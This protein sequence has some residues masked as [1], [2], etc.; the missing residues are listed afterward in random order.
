MGKQEHLGYFSSENIID[1]EQLKSIDALTAS[2]M[3]Q[4][5][6]EKTEASGGSS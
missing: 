1:L 6:V 4:A 2:K 5:S 3:A